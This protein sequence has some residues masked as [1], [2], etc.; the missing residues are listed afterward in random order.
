MKKIILFVLYVLFSL[1]ACAPTAP[2]TYDGLEGEIEAAKAE[3]D[4]K[5]IE[6]AEQRLDKFEKVAQR[7]AAHY[8]NRAA[9]VANHNYRWVCRGQERFNPEK[10]PRDTDELV[11]IYRRDDCGCMSEEAVRDMLRS[12]GY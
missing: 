12:I 11:R 8:E 5:R 9:C 3:G 10:P 7:A 4:P 1:A 6:K 2:F